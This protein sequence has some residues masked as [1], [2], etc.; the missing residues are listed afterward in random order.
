MTFAVAFV[1]ATLGGCLV[2]SSSTETRTG[3]Y[4]PE[5]TFSRLEPGRTTASFVEAT[6]GAPD[7]RTKIDDGSE[8]WRWTYTERSE[9]SGSVFLIFGGSNERK[10]DRSAFVQIKDGVVVK[11]WRS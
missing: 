11:A 3:N 9:S 1:S 7:S 5:S 4:V 8:I 6:L 10:V 2:N